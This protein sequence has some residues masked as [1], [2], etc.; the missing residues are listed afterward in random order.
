MQ[1]AIET[2]ELYAATD[3]HV[4]QLA[5]AAHANDVLAMRSLVDAL[6]V[7]IASPHRAAAVKALVDFI[8][9]AEACTAAFGAA[10]AGAIEALRLLH[11]CGADLDLGDTQIGVTPSGV[12]AQFGHTAA[13]R[14]LAELRADVD[15]PSNDGYRPLADAA[16]DGHVDTA[17]LLLQLRADVNAQTTQVTRRAGLQRPRATIAWSDCSSVR[18]RRS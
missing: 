18:A 15:K 14:L 8:D 9:P 16:R 3:D 11:E 17:K 12:A 2:A 7:P 10:H 5:D 4:L 6:P 1:A 13:I